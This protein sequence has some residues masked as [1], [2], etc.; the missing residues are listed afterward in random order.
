MCIRDSFSNILPLKKAL[1]ELEQGKTLIFDF[2]DGY[3]I[4]HT[5]MTFIHDFQQNYEAQGGHCRQLGNALET[6]SD[7]ALAA[8]LMT[9]DDRL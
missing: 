2:S 3:L 6:F 4:D 7:H 8:R 5:V 1:A 9:A